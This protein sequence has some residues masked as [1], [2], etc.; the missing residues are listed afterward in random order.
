VILS[1]PYGKRGVFFEEW[2]GGLEWERYEVPAQECPRI[3]E[4]FLAEE[5]RSLPDWIYRQEY[6]CSF[7]ETE[8]AVFT[9]EMVDAAVSADVTPLFEEGAA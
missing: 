6:L 2:T 8:D 9:T 7:E 1:T 4:A 5:R 3:S